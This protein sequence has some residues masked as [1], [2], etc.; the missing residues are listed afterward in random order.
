ML[1]LA[2]LPPMLLQLPLLIII[3]IITLHL[4]REARRLHA[5]RGLYEQLAAMQRHHYDRAE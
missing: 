5:T 4:L 1:L 3:I 2:L